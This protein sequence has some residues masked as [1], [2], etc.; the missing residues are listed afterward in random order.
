FIP[1]FVRHGACQSVAF[2]FDNVCY[3]SDV[4]KI[5]EKVYKLLQGCDLLILDTYHPS[6]YTD[7]HFG[8]TQ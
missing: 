8:L 2:R 6:A 3:I 4:S 1:L 5:P 7:E